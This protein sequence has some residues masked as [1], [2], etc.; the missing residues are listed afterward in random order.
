[1]QAVTVDS[2]RPPRPDELPLGATV[3]GDGVGF[4]LW[5][6]KAQ[7]VELVLEGKRSIALEPQPNGYFSSY[8]KGIGAGT[9]YGF[10]LNGEGNV[11]P[12]PVS[13]RQPNGVLSL[14]EVVEHTQF[15]WSDQH[16]KGLPL[17]KMDITEAHV[18]TLTPKGTFA[19]AQPAIKAMVANTVELMPV[20]QFPGKR[21]WGYDPAQIFA[22]QHS[23]GTPDELRGLV[24]AAHNANKAVLLDVVHN[25][26][27]PEG[28]FSNAYGPYFEGPKTPW[29]NGVAVDGPQGREVARHFVENALFW[30][31][32]Y[33]VDGLRFDATVYLPKNLLTELSHAT[34]QVKK[35]TGRELVLISE[36]NRNNR[37]VTQPVL[38]G[39]HGF[40][41]QWSMDL[42]Y[43]LRA[44]LAG[45][46]GW[47][48]DRYTDD[49][50]KWATRAIARG[51]AYEGQTSPVD[52][53][54]F[55]TSAAHLDPASF[56]VAKDDH[57]QIG[58]T[59]KGARLGNRVGPA[60]DRAIDALYGFL[61]YTL[62]NF[63]GDEYRAPQPFDFFVDVK[64]PL[65][66]QIRSGRNREWA[67]WLGD[68]GAFRDPNAV[69]TFNGNK[70]KAQDRQ[71]SAA[72][73]ALRLT[74]ELA[75][76]RVE[77]PA[78]NVRSNAH[79]EVVAFPEQRTLMQRRWSP[80]GKSEM[81]ALTNLSDKRVTID[82]GTQGVIEPTTEQA[83]ARRALTGKWK[84]TLNTEE[85]RFGG[86]GG[87]FKQ[88][89]PLDLGKKSTVT[90]DPSSAM[91]LQAS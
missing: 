78:L 56:V 30:M 79:Y 76:L 3:W 7:K 63:Q 26:P 34:A 77:N 83:V 40:D 64:E 66:S 15:K 13:H 68:N 21:N 35:V 23:Y 51:W 80:D 90:L 75:K 29:G 39:G 85:S 86:K 73:Q 82:L 31:N 37:A 5:A 49:P 45:E 28:A 61:P 33:H 19:S 25:H 18:G 88:G 67:E 9:R 87:G 53:G 58:N 4:L 27:G 70:L 55:G 81:L 60:S 84:V 24:N 12:D 41:G 16:W 43:A 42:Q 71:T 10:K 54:P 50:F 65:A 57:D 14:S 2:T 72:K 89:E 6:P 47:R 48:I 8:V 46:K 20:H 74:Q 22:V 44:L 17:S 1:M 59:P 52:K 38:A 11:M 36:N 69:T 62:M 32:E 91:Y